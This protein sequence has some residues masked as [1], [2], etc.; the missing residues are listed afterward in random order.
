MVYAI[1]TGTCGTLLGA[2]S[3]TPFSVPFILSVCWNCTCH[4]LPLRT[5]DLLTRA[6]LQCSTFS[7]GLSSATTPCLRRSIISSRGFRLFGGSSARSWGPTS[8]PSPSSVPRTSSRASTFPPVRSS[9]K[10]EEGTF[11][12]LLVWQAKLAPGT[13][14]RSSPRRS[15]TSRRPT[16]PATVATAS[17]ATEVTTSV[18][19]A[20]STRRSGRTGAFS[21]VSLSSSRLAV[22]R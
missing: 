4:L 13:P 5:S 10:L 19:S 9:H 22:G 15:V 11:L 21:F 12:T 14:R 2:V 7:A 17:S 16:P 3:P 6:T 1:F 20:T 8:S 18:A